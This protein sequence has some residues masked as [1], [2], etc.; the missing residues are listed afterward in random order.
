MAHMKIGSNLPK[1]LLEIAQENILNGDVEKGIITF[2]DSLNGFNKE[3]A[4][5]CLKNEAVLVVNEE[6]QTMVLDDDEQLRNENQEYIY[7]WNK[8]LNDQEIH[9]V[10]LANNLQETKQLF[11]NIK[12]M[13]ARDIENY[14][15]QNMML[16]YFSEEQV[17]KIGVHNLAAKL[18]K[19]DDF[20]LNLYGNGSTVWQHL[21]D[22]VETD[23][24]VKFYEKALYYTVKYVNIIRNIHR[25]YLKFDK[26][27][28]FLVDNGLAK[29][30]L[31]VEQVVRRICYILKEFSD[32]N[33]GYYHG[34]CDEALSDYKKQIIED[35]KN[36]TWGNE[37]LE[38]NFLLTNIEDGYDAG[39]LSPNG[40]FIGANGDTSSLIHMC[41]AEDIWKGNSIYGKRMREDNVSQYSNL[42][43][44]YW[45]E[46]EG[47]LKIHHDEIYGYFKYK[48]N[49]EIIHKEDKVLYCPTEKQIEMIC[50]YVDKFYNGKFYM[51]PL[52]LR[53]HYDKPLYTRDIKQMDEIAL[54]N[55]F[56]H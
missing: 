49:A 20:A 5:M 26:Q 29:K 14:S 53:D 16:E 38:N 45:L 6:E 3:Y 31:F 55:A 24:D 4:L 46:K 22:K 32:L 44:E 18:I 2:T 33:K 52:I 25:E 8:L 54:H 19:G 39:W 30:I 15:L 47:W 1:I 34:M 43:P 51:A 35:I 21:C 9:L 7:D 11:E 10:N 12:G 37:Y 50:K 41:L 42:S 56:T 13:R 36:T 27:Y 28:H 40:M 23:I 17:S 48:K